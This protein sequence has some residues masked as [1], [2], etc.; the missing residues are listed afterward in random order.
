MKNEEDFFNIMQIKR[1]KEYV[2]EDLKQSKMKHTLT[3]KLYFSF[4]RV[5]QRPDIKKE[6]CVYSS[7]NRL[8]FT[9]F[10]FFS[11]EIVFEPERLSPVVPGAII[12]V[13][14]ASVKTPECLGTCEN[15]R[16]NLVRAWPGPPGDFLFRF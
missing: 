1:K 11:K 8:D 3:K 6:K 12:P 2:R 4:L 10:K 16:A 7:S 5:N 13:E 15:L 14:G 9:H